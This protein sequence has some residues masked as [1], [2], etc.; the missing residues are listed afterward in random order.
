MTDVVI[1]SDY[2]GF[3]LS[4]EAIVK[5]FELKNWKLVKRDMVSGVT[6]YYKDSIEDHNLFY[7]H[8]LCRDDPDLVQ[9]VKKLGKRANG[10]YASLRIVTIPDEVKW[11]INEYDG[12]EHVAED[13]RT[14][15]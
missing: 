1:N 4:H 7:E 6:F 12:R 3:G 5:L 9:V 14:W 8:D 15:Y 11:H 13:H 10:Q 2:G